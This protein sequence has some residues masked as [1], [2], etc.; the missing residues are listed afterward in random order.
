MLL[1]GEISKP[2]MEILGKFYPIFGQEARS[3]R[4]I[5]RGRMLDGKGITNVLSTPALENGLTGREVYPNT[6]I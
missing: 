6:G 3:Q 2:K 4:K 1:D 5:D